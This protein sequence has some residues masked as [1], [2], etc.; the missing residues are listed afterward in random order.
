V[1][2]DALRKIIDGIR[3]RGVAFEV[4]EDR[5]RVRRR[6]L[7]EHEVAALT[8]DPDAVHRLLCAFGSEQEEEQE[9]TVADTLTL[10][11]ATVAPS[12]EPEPR[13]PVRPLPREK[14]E[15]AGIE[16]MNG[17]PTCS[18]GGDQRAEQIILG[19]IS[20]EAAVAQREATRSMLRGIQRNQ[21]PFS[22]DQ[23]RTVRDFLRED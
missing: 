21:P 13:E 1:S 11:P 18:L 3:A 17:V 10:R 14:W 5:W 6:L 12:P 9:T 23:A 8:A 2:D 20:Y 15:A 7:S 19:Q 16:V 4:I 22:L